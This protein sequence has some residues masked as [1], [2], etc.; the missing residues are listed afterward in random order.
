MNGRT[1]L[2]AVGVS[3]SLLLTLAVSTLNTP[4]ASGPALEFRKTGGIAGIKNKLII[5]QNGTVV[6]TSSHSGSFSAALR[7]FDFQE[8]KRTISTNIDAISNAKYPAKQGAA[9][10]F[11]YKFVSHLEGKN[12]SVTWVDEWATDGPFPEQLKQIQKAL[13]KTLQIL[14]A[15]SQYRDKVVAHA[16]LKCDG[17]GVCG[18]L[19][20]ELFTD[21]TSYNLGEQVRIFVALRNS[22]TRDVNY[23]SPTPCHPDFRITVNGKGSTQDVSFSNNP[24]V[25]CIQVLQSRTLHHG[26][27]L[28]QTATWDASFDQNGMRINAPPGA[29]TIGARFPLAT[30]EPSLLEAST[31]ITL[32]A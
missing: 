6:F 30:F 13:D 4:T 18:A 2:L 24:V 21:K 27:S 28:I 7:T 12:V 31:Q 19:E 1:A 9:D 15:E 8:L 25:A 23:T 10:Y 22:G 29:Y 16:D 5:S 17:G 26:E 3:L 11:G 32:N 20:V 14:S